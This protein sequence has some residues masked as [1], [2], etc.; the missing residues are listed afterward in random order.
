MII[1]YGAGIVY[2]KENCMIGRADAR[3]EGKLVDVY[4]RGAVLGYKEE[5]GRTRHAFCHI[6][7]EETRQGR[8]EIIRN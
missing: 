7:L 6:K 3:Y 5:T 1:S 4:F 8:G 2:I